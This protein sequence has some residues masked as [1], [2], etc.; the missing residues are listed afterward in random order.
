MLAI[1]K[2]IVQMQGGIGNQLFQYA[3]ARALSVQ[4]GAEL[5]IDDESGFIKDIKYKR[6]FGLAAL[7][8]PGRVATRNEKLL[9][10]RSFKKR[11]LKFMNKG[12]HK[13]KQIF[14]RDRQS[15][16]DLDMS[17]LIPSPCLWVEGVWANEQYFSNSAE[18]ISMDIFRNFIHL[19]DD[20]TLKLI[21]APNCVAVHFRFF[22][23][24]SHNKTDDIGMNYYL[25]AINLMSAKVPN[26]HFLIFSDNG[27]KAKE[28]MQKSDFSWSL[29]QALS[30][31][32]KDLTT[33][34]LREL[35]MLSLASHLIASNS[36]FSW[37]ATWLGEN[38][39][40]SRVAILPD[41]INFAS[42]HWCLPGL[43]PDRWMK[44]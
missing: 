36:T 21:S 17:Q 19:I 34:D 29:A 44:I 5:V 15:G 1:R 38:R 9:P 10:F 2:I 40:P 20:E 3:F 35:L 25:R 12:R 32:V 11:I 7:D 16:F 4:T 43:I 24:I 18:I 27:E 8:L 23:D 13:T 30:A 31:D 14:I 42:D 41:P 26:A 39:N 33:L 37:W 22:S 28:L 6:K